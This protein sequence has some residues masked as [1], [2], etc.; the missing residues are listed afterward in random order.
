V[1]TL[2]PSRNTFERLATEDPEALVEMLR[3]LHDQPGLLTHGAEIAGERLPGD[4]AVP[5]LLGLLERDSA[6]V[7]EGAVL[8]LAYHPTPAVQE[9]LKRLLDEDSSPG[10]RETV[11]DVFYLLELDEAELAYEDGGLP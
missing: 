10:V 5:L 7:R 1:T 3:G 4:L 9:R 2:R 8:G 11:E 6:L